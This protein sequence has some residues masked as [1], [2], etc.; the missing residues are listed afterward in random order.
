M[1]LRA[2]ALSFVATAAVVGCGKEGAPAEDATSA[3]KTESKASKSDSD[4]AA[5]DDS[6]DDSAK[7]DAK[8]KK[9][10]K[11]DDGLTLH[12]KAKDYLIAPDVVFMYSFNESDAKDKA[13]K[14][15]E[16][17]SKGDHEKQAAC[18]A[19]AQKKFGADGYHFA[20]DDA[21][22]WWWETVKIKNGTIVYLHRVPIEFGKETEET[23]EVKVTGKD[24]AKGAK[25]YVPNEVTFSVP[26]AYQIV[27]TDPDEGKIVFEAK[28]GLL[29]DQGTKKKR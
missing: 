29:G 15:C 6:A 12:R 25:G 16:E 23:I 4:K 11:V 14:S 5:T 7:E 2:L 1:R 17:K 26:N 27:Q 9:K 18:M 8:P 3:K 13:E 19:S 28:L 22:K 20:P 21:G 10:K 24:E